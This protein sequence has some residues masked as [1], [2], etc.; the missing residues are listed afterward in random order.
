MNTDDKAAAEKLFKEL[1]LNMSTAFTLFIKQSIRSG[2]LPFPV[3]VN[4]EELFY[5]KIEKSFCEMKKGERISADDVFSE[6]R[7][8]Y[9]YEKI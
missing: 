3:T 2:G 4:A 1:G 9:G 6:L 5:A 8:K 7:E